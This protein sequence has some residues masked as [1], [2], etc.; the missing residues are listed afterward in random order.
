MGD[1]ENVSNLRIHTVRITYSTTKEFLLPWNN[2]KNPQ[3]QHG[4]VHILRY[5][6]PAIFSEKSLLL[7]ILF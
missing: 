2:N 3:K 7:A 1:P 4:G 5:N 6:L